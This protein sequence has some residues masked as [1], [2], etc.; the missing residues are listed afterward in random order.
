MVGS[1][2]A[3]S[4][5]DGGPPRMT[6]SSSWWNDHTP[7]RADDRTGPRRM[8]NPNRSRMSRSSGPRASSA[9]V[10][11]CWEYLP[12]RSGSTS[13]TGN[14]PRM[15]SQSTRRSAVARRAT[16]MLL[17]S[18]HRPRRPK[19][20]CSLLRTS[21]AGAGDRSI[22]TATSSV[23]PPA[24]RC[25]STRRCHRAKRSPGARTPRR[26]GGGSASDRVPQ[27]RR[28]RSIGSAQDERRD[29]RRERDDRCASRLRQAVVHGGLVHPSP[30]GQR[31]SI[32]NP[33][34]VPRSGIDDLVGVGL[35]GTCAPPSR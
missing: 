22:T 28:S 10:G 17:Y 35:P 24:W 13:M 21:C 7:C 8:P 20:R 34:V 30:G 25:S 5:N 18:C 29:H 31:P 23:S 1:S 2:S 32:A 14:P 26:S 33:T 12:T 11:K 19:R 9:A 3:T 16:H 6:C 27:G 4:Q 15:S